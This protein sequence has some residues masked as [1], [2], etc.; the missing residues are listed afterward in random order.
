MIKCEFS[1]IYTSSAII[2]ILKNQFLNLLPIFFISWTARQFSK[3]VGANPEDFP[4]TV[5][6]NNE[7]RVEYFYS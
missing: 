2:F 7:R 3:D 1:T 4:D 6:N 5:N